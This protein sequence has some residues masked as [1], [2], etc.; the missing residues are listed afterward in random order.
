MF[1][2]KMKG[3]YLALLMIFHSLFLMNSL[4]QGFEINEPELTIPL[5]R[6]QGGSIHNKYPIKL[7]KNSE[8]RD[9]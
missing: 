5:H 7:D 6:K 9:I 1:K 8:F 3:N 2:L 4:S